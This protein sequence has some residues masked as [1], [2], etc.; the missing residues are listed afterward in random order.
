MS[1][2]KYTFYTAEE[3]LEYLKLIM[4]ENVFFYYIKSLT[5]FRYRYL[6]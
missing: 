1:K 2:R 4:E 6:I 3:K 5:L